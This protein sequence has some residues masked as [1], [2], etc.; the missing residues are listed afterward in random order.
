MQPVERLL[1]LIAFLL[2]SPRGVTAAEIREKVEGYDGDRTD[3]A[4]DR[5]FER[6]K[7]ELR[8]IGVPIVVDEDEYGESAYRIDEEAYYLPPVD[9]TAEE[10][11]ALRIAA[12]VLSDDAAYPFRTEMR[13]ALAKL[14]SDVPLLPDSNPP[15]LV[16]LGGTAFEPEQAKN[17]ELLRQATEARKQVDFDY[18]SISSD[19]QKR[20]RVDP[21]ALFNRNGRWYVAAFCHEASDVRTFRLSRIRGRV[22]VNSRKPHTPDFE[23]PA[24]FSPESLAREPWETGEERTEV[25][26]AFEAPLRPWALAHFADRLEPGEGETLVA[27]LECGD[28]EA[29]VRWLL[30]FGR[31]VTMLEPT[32][33]RSLV[34]GTLDDMLALYENA[35]NK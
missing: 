17:L 30:S 21:Y 1:N 20:R 33:L 22:E 32:A 25:R 29:F 5:M 16:R 27:R 34:R 10:A 8:E 13:S 4:F 14:A 7:D 18:Y 23:V 12:R 28:E 11:L 9:L 2:D 6:D 15:L 35:A 26:L 3:E 19:R 31:Q 24:Q